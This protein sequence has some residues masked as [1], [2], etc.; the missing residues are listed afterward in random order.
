[1]VSIVCFSIE[2]RPEEHEGYSPIASCFKQFELVYVAGDER[3]L[4]SA[5]HQFS[6]RNG[7]SLPHRYHAR[8]DAAVVPALLLADE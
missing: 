1:M 8:G 7:V 3:D 5:A 4:R 2:T 6:G